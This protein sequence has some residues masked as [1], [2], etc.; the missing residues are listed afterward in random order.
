MQGNKTLIANVTMV[1]RRTNACCPA[2]KP[3]KK[4]RTWKKRWQ[5]LL[6]FD[7]AAEGDDDAK[8]EALQPL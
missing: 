4:K 7:F 1:N 8:R 2:S 6:R 5:F 3:T